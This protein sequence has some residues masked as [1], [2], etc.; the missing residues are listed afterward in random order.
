MNLHHLR[1]FV[2][3]ADAGG[4]ARAA[5]RLN[6]TQPTASRQIQALETELGVPLFDRIGRRVQLTSEGEDLL[7]RSRNLLMEADLLSERALVLKGGQAG[8]LRVGAPPH[9]IETVLA[10]FLARYARRHPGIEVRIVEDGGARLPDYL[11]RGEVHLTFMPAG[12]DRFLG[13]LLFPIHVVAVLWEGHRL[14]RRA[15]LEIAEVADD[16]I[17]VLRRGFGSRAWF[18]AACQVAHLRPRVLLESAAPDTITALAR[19]GYGIA[20]VPSN[21]EFPRGKLHAVPLVHRA[22]SIG[23]WAMIGWHPQRFLA[24]YAEQFI[25]ELVAYCRPAYPGHDLIRR[26]PRLARP[27]MR[28]A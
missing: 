4:V 13:R 25:E 22:A 15:L 7:R 14:S 19:A 21:I 18:D 20:V 6:L 8:T 28:V 10:G 12:D 9:V 23:R 1:T 3:I 24:P 16:P 17:L 26:A 5:T 2:T 27:K 11:E